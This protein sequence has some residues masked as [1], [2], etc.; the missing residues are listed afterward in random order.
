M[1]GSEEFFPDPTAEN[2]PQQ[3]IG[4]DIVKVCMKV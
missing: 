4:E 1:L 3:C 2:V